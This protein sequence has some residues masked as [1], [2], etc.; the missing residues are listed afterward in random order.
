MKSRYLWNLIRGKSK[1]INPARLDLRHIWAVI[2]C[3]I[4]SIL[5]SPLHI[6][7]QIEWRILQVKE[8]SP[9][10]WEEGN[11]IQCG[12]EIKGKVKADIGCDNEPFCYPQMMRKKQWKQY[13]SDKAIYIY[14]TNICKY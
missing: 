2:Q 13:K 10:C 14:K 6:R 11:C 4:R 1:A 8:K 5:P 12:C 3:Q 9:K 7:E